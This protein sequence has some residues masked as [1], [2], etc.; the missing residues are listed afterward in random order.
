MADKSVPKYTI[1]NSLEGSDPINFAG[2]LRGRIIIPQT[3]SLT[4]LTWHE[5]PDGGETWVPSYYQ[6]GDDI[7]SATEVAMVQSVTAG[8]AIDMPLNFEAASLLKA[9]GDVP[10]EIYISVV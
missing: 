4:S 9:V 1:G 6:T 2:H 5:S 7:A 8:R 10:G 3:E